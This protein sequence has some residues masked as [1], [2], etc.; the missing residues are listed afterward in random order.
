MDIILGPPYYQ[1]SQRW[2]TYHQITTATT[3]APPIDP[4]MAALVPTPKCLVSHLIM[5]NALGGSP[6]PGAGLLEPAGAPEE[7]ALV[8]E[9]VLVVDVLFANRL[10][11]IVVGIVPVPLIEVLITASYDESATEVTAVLIS[12]SPSVVSEPVKIASCEVAP[13]ASEEELSTC[14]A[15]CCAVST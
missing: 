2:E 3:A 5:L 9:A 11:E 15:S 14:R 13:S 7:I 8:V 12:E 1:P 4:P 6:V 10:S